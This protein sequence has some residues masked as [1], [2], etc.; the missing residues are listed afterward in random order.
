LVTDEG[1][2]SYYAHVIRRSPT[3][4]LDQVCTVGHDGDCKP[5][6]ACFDYVYLTNFI[7]TGLKRLQTKWWQS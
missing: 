5:T 4:Q 3:K 6:S 2:E 1:K 7:Q